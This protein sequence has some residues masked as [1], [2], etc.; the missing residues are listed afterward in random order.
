MHQ[1][2]CRVIDD[3]EE[4]LQQQMTEALNEHHEDNV[5]PVNPELSSANTQENFPGIKKGIKLPKLP[6][7]WSPANDFFKHDLFKLSSQIV[8]IIRRVHS[9]KI[10][11]LKISVSLRA[12]V[13]VSIFPQNNK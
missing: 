8:R 12:L 13:I 6:L 9:V 7:Q 5:E 10:Q 4:E 2:S 11:C 3:L 1:R